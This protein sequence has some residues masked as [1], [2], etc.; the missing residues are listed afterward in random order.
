MMEEWRPVVG[1]EGRYEVSDMG[2]VRSLR[3]GR[4]HLR[5]KPFPIKQWLKTGDSKWGKGYWVVA[6][7]RDNRTAFRRVHR[8]ILEAFVGPCPPG[9]ESSHLNGNPFHC[10]LANLAWETLSENQQ[11]KRDH[12]TSR[13][14]PSVSA[15]LTEDMVR[16]ARRKRQE[17]GTPHEELAREYGVC[18]TA[19]RNAISGKTWAHVL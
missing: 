18:R 14:G 9:H 19:I 7:C 6:L 12:G 2:N 11:R 5:K 4:G 16:E 3:G 13:I 10:T 17:W 15:K 1:W 8:L